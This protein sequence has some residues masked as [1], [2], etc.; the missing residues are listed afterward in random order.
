MCLRPQ[1]VFEILPEYILYIMH[2]YK[3]FHVKSE[4][5]TLRSKTYVAL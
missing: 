2:T 4:Y 3:T 5:Y 1:D